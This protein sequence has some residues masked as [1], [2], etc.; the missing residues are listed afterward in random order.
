MVTRH[1]TE[2][3]KALRGVVVTDAG[4]E[5]PHALHRRGKID[6][7]AGRDFDAEARGVPH[8]GGGAGGADDAF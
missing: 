2:I 7:D 1:G 8:V 5:F 4:A 6:F 3:A